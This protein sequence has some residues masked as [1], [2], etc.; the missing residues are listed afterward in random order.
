[1][2]EAEKAKQLVLEFPEKHQVGMQVIIE[3]MKLLDE[4]LK[5]LAAIY[6]VLAMQYAQ[7][8]QKDLSADYGRRCVETL[9]A[10]GDRT[11]K[12]C[13]TNQIELFGVPLP[14]F[15]HDELVITMLSAHGVTIAQTKEGGK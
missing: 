7:L 11:L 4:T 3:T 10:H 2:G 13:A 1:M 8:G 6:Y 15:L 14:E 9:R 12:D 5:E